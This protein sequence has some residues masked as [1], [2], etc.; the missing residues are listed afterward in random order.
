MAL[1]NFL[2]YSTFIFA[3]IGILHL[4]RVLYEWPAYIGGWVVPMWISWL[5]V[6]VAVLLVWS[7][8]KLRKRA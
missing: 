2:S 4:L 5:V 3:A 6:I 8:L 1:K 7:G